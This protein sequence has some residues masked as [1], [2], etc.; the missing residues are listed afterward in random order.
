MMSSVRDVMPSPPRLRVEAAAGP[1]FELL[2]GLYAATTPDESRATSWLPTRATWSSE[3]VDAVAAVGERSGEVWL[4]LLGL[5]LELPHDD[6]RSF[7]DAVARVPQRELRRHLAGAFVPAWVGMAGAETL[8]RAAAGDEAAIERLLAHPRYYAGRAAESLGP[9]LVLPARETK[10]RVVTALT[11]FAEEAFAPHEAEA[12]GRLRLGA[13]D[14]RALLTTYTPDEV[15]TRVTGGYVYEPEPE[16]D[17]VLLVPHLAGRPSLMLCQH[18]TDRII[19]Y[20]LAEEHVDPETTLTERA[21]ALGRALG[22][23]RRVQILRHLALRDASLD[24]LAEALGLARSTAH[25]HLG[26]LRAA[27]LVTLRGNARGYW[28]MLRPEGLADAQRALGRLAHAPTEV[29]PKRRRSTR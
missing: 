14:A 18:R 28:Y 22:D 17:R 29:P 27:G 5:A 4:H 15:V 6:A 24:E 9:L 12:V 3:L 10:D 1:A 11:R 19:C 2:I 7:V 21:V 8:E 16:L 23:E 20:P 26:Q 13:E 25:H